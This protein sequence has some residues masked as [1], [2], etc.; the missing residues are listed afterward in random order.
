M[1]KLIFLWTTLAMLSGSNPAT[2]E[3]SD[4]KVSVFYDFGWL[5]CAIVNKSNITL[6]CYANKNEYHKSG[7]PLFVLQ[8]TIGA[9]DRRP[10]GGEED[11]TACRVSFKV[12]YSDPTKKSFTPKPGYGIWYK[13]NPNG[14]DRLEMEAGEGMLD[15]Q[16]AK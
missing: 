11:P 13:V 14:K 16:I 9:P 15:V 5:H 6:L 3:S 8:G 2:A 4:Y 12:L 10:R 1:K 7:R